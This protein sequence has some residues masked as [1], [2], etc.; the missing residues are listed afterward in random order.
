MKTKLKDMR[1]ITTKNKY[2]TN[3]IEQ[4]KTDLEIKI[5]DKCH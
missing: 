4:K 2:P 5:K 3:H 1:L